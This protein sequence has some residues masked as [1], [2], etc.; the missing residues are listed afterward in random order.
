MTPQSRGE[1]GGKRGVRPSV[2]GQ[3]VAADKEG[4]GR[5]ADSEA[6]A[7]AAQGRQGFTGSCRS[8]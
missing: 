3:R 6:V 5:K 4:A 1:A 8:P 2:R 7:Q